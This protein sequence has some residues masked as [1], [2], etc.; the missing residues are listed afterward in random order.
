M[1]IFWLIA[2]AMAGFIVWV[3][4]TG[5]IRVRGRVLADRDVDRRQFWLYV[6][7]MAAGLIVIIIEAMFSPVPS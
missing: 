7:V 2:V 5:R 4:F 6:A 1:N 3:L